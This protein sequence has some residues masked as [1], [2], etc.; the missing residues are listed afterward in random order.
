MR[1]LALRLPTALQFHPNHALLFYTGGVCRFTYLDCAALYFSLQSR[2]HRIW[3]LVDSNK[4]LAK[5]TETFDF[6]MPFFVVEAA[7]PRAPC[8]E[9]LKKVK[10]EQFCM[11][12]WTFSEV[13]QACVGPPHGRPQSSHFL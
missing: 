5:P 12:R 7:A 10:P 2:F 3:V 4:D 13:L 1:R 6:R 9:W 11:D 8:I